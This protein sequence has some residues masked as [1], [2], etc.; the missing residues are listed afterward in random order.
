MLCIVMLGA[1]ATPRG[2]V[3]ER[4]EASWYG[5]NFHGKLTANG[6]TYDQNG[7]TAAHRTLPFDTRVRVDNL[8]NGESVTVRINDRGPYAHGR[9]IDLSKKAAE[10]IS[11]IN[12]GV[13]RVR[14]TLV[15][16]KEP[17]S[18]RGIS[19]EVFTVQ[20]ASFDSREEARNHSRDINGTRVDRARA[21]D[22]T[23]YRVFYGSYRNR[24]R[25]ERALTRLRRNGYEGFV[26]QV[27]N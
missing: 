20:L 18:R 7:L 12:S 9:I 1:C 13:A 27:Q 4:G 25:A 11:M 6:E 17:V 21:G 24:E 8:D 10:E 19:R 23:V 14:I 15:D 3:L 5:P 22:R 26:K 16:S 2:M